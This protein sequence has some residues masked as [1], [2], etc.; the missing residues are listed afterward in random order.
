MFNFNLSV[1]IYR[2]IVL[3]V[4]KYDDLLKSQRTNEH[5]KTGIQSLLIYLSHNQV[6]EKSGHS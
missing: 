2:S 1:K 4:Q 6:P 3:N 5:L